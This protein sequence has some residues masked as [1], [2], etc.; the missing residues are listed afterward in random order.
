MHNRVVVVNSTPIIALASIQRLDL[1]KALYE[2]TYIPKAVFDE[3]MI[4]DNSQAQLE[5]VKARE[6]I[7]TKSISN[8]EAKKFFK[9]QLHEG[10]V[11]V[12]ILGLEISADLLVIDD[13][14]AREYAKYLDFKVTGSL[15]VL[16]R[17]KEKGIIPKI[18]PLMNDFIENGIYISDKL[19]Y[20]IL[21]IA[22]ED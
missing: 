8:N 16:L 9:V 12:M 6:W 22:E 4:K 3:V 7:I 1:F 13:Y 18:K 2:V 14:M 19:Y 11:E 20:D 17:A 10:E 5:L 21:E 15:G